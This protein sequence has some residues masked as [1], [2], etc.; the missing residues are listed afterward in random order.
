M[1][2]V[3]KALFQPQATPVNNPGATRGGWV[4]THTN[5]P[6]LHHARNSL[7]SG[8]HNL[9]ATACALRLPILQPI[10]C[11]RRLSLLTFVWEAKP[12]RDENTTAPVACLWDDITPNARLETVHSNDGPRCVFAECLLVLLSIGTPMD[13]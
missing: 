12:S 11:T 1:H 3:I 6:K 2:H 5:F 8:T 7:R 10:Q 4:A 9:V 13:T